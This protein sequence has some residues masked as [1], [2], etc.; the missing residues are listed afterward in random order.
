MEAVYSRLKELKNVPDY[1]RIITKK[2]LFEDPQFKP[3][4]TSLFSNSK[5]KFSQEKVDKWKSRVEW[6]RIKDI[7]DKDEITIVEKIRAGDVVQGEIGDWYFMSTLTTPWQAYFVLGKLDFG[8]GKLD[9][10]L[11]K[12]DFVLG[13]PIL[14]WQPDL[15]LETQSWTKIPLIRI[16]Q[17]K[18]VVSIITLNYTF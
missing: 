16:Y 1:K 17:F 13:N 6:R 10:G 14:D 15:G 11:G 3:E 18:F 5:S 12:L 8:L 4:K 9:F 2:I 7:Y